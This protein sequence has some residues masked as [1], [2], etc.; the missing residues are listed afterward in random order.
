[1][2]LEVSGEALVDGIN[3]ED[4]ET[5]PFGVAAAPGE[6]D[7]HPRLI[8]PTIR[9]FARI[10][11]IA[12]NQRRVAGGRETGDRLFT[13]REIGALEN[14]SRGMLALLERK[15]SVLRRIAPLPPHADSV[16]WLAVE[17][18]TGDG[19]RRRDGQRRALV[20]LIMVVRRD[21][22]IGTGIDSD[23]ERDGCRAVGAFASRSTIVD[24]DHGNP[25]RAIGIGP[26]GVGESAVR[27]NRRAGGKEIRIG[28]AGHVEDELLLGFFSR[29]GG[30][31]FRPSGD[32]FGGGVFFNDLIWSWRECGS[33]VH[34]SDIDPDGGN[35]AF[36]GPVGGPVPERIGADEVGGGDIRERAVAV[37]R[38]FSVRGVLHQDRPKWIL[39]WISVAMK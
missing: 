35:V 38:K 8:R 39:F 6:L 26:W 5:S 31:I 30:N 2:L 14:D 37:K 12:T 19:R 29:A 32:R 17:K 20:Q 11:V 25:G 7:D 24:G 27:R 36:T 18:Y 9:N 22:S 1:M 13:G 33:I 34:G 3:L 21:W 28:I 23:V 10:H 15:S 16:T 4:G